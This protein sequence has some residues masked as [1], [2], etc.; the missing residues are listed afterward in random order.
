MT[1]SQRSRPQLSKARPSTALQTGVLTSLVYLLVLTFLTACAPA[2]QRTTS[3]EATDAPVAVDRTLRIVMRTEPFDLTDGASGRN[4][5]T[6]AMF[7][8][9]LSK[10][11]AEGNPTP[12]LLQSLPT[13]N[14]SD[15][16]VFS[17]GRMETTYRLRPNVTW[18]D[19]A[20]FTAD[21]IVF[22]KRLNTVA[23]DW[24]LSFSSRLTGDDYQEHVLA[25][26]VE[27]LDP[28]TV[29]IRWK[30]PFFLA[31]S[32]RMR[33]VARHILEP[34]MQPSQPDLLG[35][36]H[37]WTTEYVGLGPYG[38]ERWEAG[39]FIDGSAFPG[40]VMGRPKMGRITV[41]WTGDPNSATSRLLAGDVDIA[42][43]ESIQSV[44]AS[45]LRQQWG[46]RGVIQILPGTYR[47]LAP[48]HRPAHANPRAILDVRVRQ[49][50]LHAIDRY[51]LVESLTD[52]QGIVAE[53]IVP[54]R[55]RFYDAVERITPRFP[56]DVAQTQR[57]MMEAGFSR[58]PD[59]S[60]VSPTEGRFNPEVLGIAEGLEGR[61]TTIVHDYLRRAG[62]DAEL[63]LVPSTQMQQSDELKATHRSFR[64]N[65]GTA[66]G[67]GMTT[68]QAATQENRWGG[69]NKAGYS[70][71]EHDRLSDLWSATL[72]WNERDRLAV[73][74]IKIATEDVANVPLYFAVKVWPHLA[75]LRGPQGGDPDS[76]PYENLHEWFWS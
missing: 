53:A 41:S 10:V 49:A 47:F 3:S 48:Q 76:T 29:L 74:A 19:G 40:Y 64:D 60:F 14:S 32:P 9:G 46:D 33:P 12:V 67:P 11:D 43:D 5:I 55:T 50:T 45:T 13:L 27:A 69:K 18:H 1:R 36:S 72:D 15:W 22:T 31:G 51:A 28:Q 42:L 62:I 63:R 8:E 38:L 26:S 16:R 7:T 2:A 6:K 58:G 65:Y 52:G 54:P 37:Y 44:H 30:Q 57:L 39:A 75:S 21:D 61:E 59:G 73:E 71:S 70:N 34:L 66:W 4:N 24:G 68:A 20:A 17:D 56:F 35:S 25:E 23:I